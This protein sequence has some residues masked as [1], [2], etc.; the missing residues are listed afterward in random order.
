MRI[1]TRYILKE[2][3]SYSLVGLLVFTFV[4]YVPRIGHL[5]ELV[6]RRDLP[7]SRVLLLFLLPVP[8]ILTLTLPMAVLVGTLLGVGRMAADGE[9]IAARS[10]GMGR[11]Q[12]ARPVVLYALGGWL[13]ASWMS[14]FLAPRGA[15][16]LTRMESELVSS[17]A[18]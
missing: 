13:L 1:L 16:E 2:I 5:L 11:G 6:V 10:V 12:F 3:L 15:F 8:S 17:Q 7:L 18:P 4:V 9:V 14:L